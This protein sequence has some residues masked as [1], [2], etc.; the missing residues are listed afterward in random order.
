MLLFF[1]VEGWWV[2]DFLNSVYLA[3]AFVK[4]GPI[5]VSVVVGEGQVS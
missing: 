4:A 5:E 1:R 2:I 3:N